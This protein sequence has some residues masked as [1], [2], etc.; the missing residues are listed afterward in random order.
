MEVTPSLCTNTYYDLRSFTFAFLAKTNKTEGTQTKY[1][2][3][4]NPDKVFKFFFLIL[5]KHNLACEGLVIGE[6]ELLTTMSE[7]L[8]TNLKNFINYKR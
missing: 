8:H 3:V 1:I 2:I 4:S 6:A 7:A 5:L